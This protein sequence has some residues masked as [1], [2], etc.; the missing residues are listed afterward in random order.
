MT[1]HFIALFILKCIAI[2]AFV[3][4]WLYWLHV[5]FHSVSAPAWF[6]RIHVKH[7]VKFNQTKVFDLEP[8]ELF[9]DCLAPFIFTWWLVNWWFFGVVLFVALFEASR[10]HGYY[11][12]FRVPKAYYRFFRFAGPKYHGVHHTVGHEH[13][14]LGQMLRWWD[15]IMST[16]AKEFNREKICSQS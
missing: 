16:G 4:T 9:L 10:G 2:S 6:R 1:V 3:D 11:S 14:N 7:H 12:W 13:E 15:I 5:G 8:V